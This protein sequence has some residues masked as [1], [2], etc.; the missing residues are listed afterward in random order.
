MTLPFAW[1]L[2]V[3]IHKSNS[4]DMI[5]EIKICFRKFFQLSERINSLLLFHQLSR[6]FKHI[7]ADAVCR[8][9]FGGTFYHLGSSDKTFLKFSGTVFKSL[10]ERVLGLFVTYSSSSVLLIWKLVI[11][12][13][14][15]YQLTNCVPESTG[16]VSV[17]FSLV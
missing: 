12:L 5:P 16:D 2:L 4:P 8:F 14:K 15:I 3:K 13:K 17:T 6:V 1:R 11:G 7:F 9:K 10:N